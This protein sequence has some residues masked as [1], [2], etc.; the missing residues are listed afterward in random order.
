MSGKLKGWGILLKYKKIIVLKGGISNESEI[1]MQTG[2][3]VT[4]ALNDKYEVLELIVNNNLKYLIKSIEQYKPDAIFN[5]LHGKFG[6]D[7]QIQSILNCLNIPYTH[8]GVLSSALAMNK[9][10]S[11]VLFEKFGISC[12]KGEKLNIQNISNFKNRLPIVIKPINGGS[13]IGVKTINSL[14]TFNKFKKEIKNYNDLLVEEFIPGRE[15][16]VGILENRVCGITEI[17]SESEFYDFESKY[18]K[19]A[20]HIQN[21]NIKDDIKEKLVKNTVLAHNLLGCNCLCRADYRYNEKKN[22]IFLLEINT[23]P[24]LTKNSLLPEMVFKK[25]LDFKKLVEI[26]V[27][28]SKCEN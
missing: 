25:G 8:S 11:K 17:V 1:S 23:Q 21:P 4:K 28:N 24:G 19:I 15:I 16:T 7:G 5:A 13:S 2:N 9:Y 12:P 26:I 20:K 6:E 27:E 18:V 10:F 22:E 14:S 3:E